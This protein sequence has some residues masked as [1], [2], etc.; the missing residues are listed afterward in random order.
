MQNTAE[1]PVS[2]SVEGDVI[3]EGLVSYMPSSVW[4]ELDGTSY[5]SEKAEQ[6]C[7]QMLSTKT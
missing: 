2:F 1:K 5:I 3:F 4:P 7:I 6:S